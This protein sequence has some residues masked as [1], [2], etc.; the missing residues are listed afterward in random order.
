[1]ATYKTMDCPSLIERWVEMTARIEHEM[2][3]LL[4]QREQIRGVAKMIDGNPRLLNSNKP[5]LWEVRRW[6]MVFAAMAVR[7]QTDQETNLVSL[8]Q[9]LLEMQERPECIT[10]AL[11]EEPFNAHYPTIADPAFKSALVDIPWKEW[12]IADGSFNVQRV[13]ND[14]DTLVQTS[15]ELYIFASATI[16]HTSQKAIEKGTKLTFDDMDKMIDLLEKLVLSYR[17]LLTGAG[18][19]TLVPT[20]Q[21]DWYEEF[22]FAWKPSER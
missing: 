17:G 8:A 10:I 4:W 12:S 20:P 16:A 1:M 15:K 2:V 11:M 6:Y 21:Y 9:L 22:R 5:F 19:W 13:S 14:L 7:R 3:D 18:G